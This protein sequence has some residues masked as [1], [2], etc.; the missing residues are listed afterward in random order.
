VINEKN[1]DPDEEEWLNVPWADNP[2]DI[3]ATIKN[4][5]REEAKSVKIEFYARDFN[6]G[7]N[8][9]EQKLGETFIDSIPMGET[10]EA[11]YVGWIPPADGHY[12]VVV[13]IPAYTHPDSGHKELSLSNNWAQSNYTKFYSGGASPA[14]R[15]I[16]KIKVKNPYDK[17]TT[18][19]VTAEQ[20]ELSFRTYLEH[21]W[22][23]M[24]AGEEREIKAM[25]EYI[26]D[27]NQI[28][29]RE[30]NL[31]TVTGWILEPNIGNW[32]EEAESTT[33]GEEIP[34]RM[35]GVEIGVLA[36]KKTQISDFNLRKAHGSSLNVTG[37]V[38]VVSTG[39]NVGAGK[40]IVRA[41]FEDSNKKIFKY[42]EDKD[43][44]SGKFDVNMPM[45]N[46]TPLT[47]SSFFKK[48]YNVVIKAYY[49]AESPYADSESEEL[50]K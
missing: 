29:S 40:V 37:N 44:S 39:A 17:K 14:E 18:I 10:K 23:N 47:I 3:V 33:K 27:V 7:G 31:V 5:G 36:G 50:K 22:L 24:E 42:G 13:R 16:K 21:T 49:I 25:F 32:Y 38:S 48:K 30:A 9:P 19:F 12:C 34:Y 35:G 8:P 43:I 15:V 4:G 28:T 6:A 26:G 2:N 20:T 1:N 11:T 46:A 41:V 45:S